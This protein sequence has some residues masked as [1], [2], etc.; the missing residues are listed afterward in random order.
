VLAVDGG[1]W[2]RASALFAFIAAVVDFFV[3]VV[4]RRVA[5]VGSRSSISSSLVL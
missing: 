4:V 5:V 1:V 2:V 3:P